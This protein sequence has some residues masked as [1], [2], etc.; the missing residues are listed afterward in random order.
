M[1]RAALD[2]RVFSGRSPEALINELVQPC[3]FQLSASRKKICGLRRFRTID[4][5]AVRLAVVCSGRANPVRGSLGH[6]GHEGLGLSGLRRWAAR[7]MAEL[8][9]GMTLEQRAT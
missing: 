1:G 9:L 8:R 7:C 6:A 2:Q 4:R 3:G 5:D